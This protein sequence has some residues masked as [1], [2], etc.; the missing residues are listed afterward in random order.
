MIDLSIVYQEI[1]ELSERV[2]FSLAYYSTEGH[3][4][5]QVFREAQPVQHIRY[6]EYDN[7]VEDDWI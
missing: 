4:E 2:Q 7:A 5:E 1:D 6:D 3:H